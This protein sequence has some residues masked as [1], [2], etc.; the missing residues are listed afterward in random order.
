[1]ATVKKGV[2][3]PSRRDKARATRRRILDSALAA[4]TE[5]GYT[6]TTVESVARDAGVAVQTV[7][8]TFRTKGD[9]LQA[10]YEHVVLGPADL[11]PHQTDWWRTVEQTGDVVT[12]VRAL[13]EGTVEL[14]DRAAPLVWAVLGDATAREGYEHNERLRRD[15][16]DHLV[17]TLAEKHPL[18]AGL[19]IATARD[20]LLVL[21]GP[22]L[23]CQLTR[24]LNWSPRAVT[25][26]MTAAVLR[27]LFAL[28][29]AASSAGT[30][31]AR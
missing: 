1:M 30:A 27:E 15:G 9:L 16:N 3:R 14:L 8:F 25:D 2:D 29:N 10:T 6:N 18:R 31:S 19:T 26:W 12:A 4:F 23:Y 21:T 24:D 22:Q 11:H 17:R 28:D 13:V 20:I 7:Y 5:R